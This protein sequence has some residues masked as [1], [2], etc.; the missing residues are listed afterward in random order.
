M[1]YFITEK[2][3]NY[4]YNKQNKVSFLRQ[5]WFG[6]KTISKSHFLKPCPKCHG[7]DKIKE[8]SEAPGFVI[9]LCN[10]CELEYLA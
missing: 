4:F 2:Q 9:C 8:L 3:S 1:S 6:S 5:L 10:R 7:N